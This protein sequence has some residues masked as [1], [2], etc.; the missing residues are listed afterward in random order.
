LHEFA[1]VFCAYHDELDEHLVRERWIEWERDRSWDSTKIAAYGDVIEGRGTLGTT[2]RVDSSAD[3]QLSLL[4]ALRGMDEAFRFVNPTLQGID[5]TPRALLRLQKFVEVHGRLSS[6]EVEGA[7]IPR[8]ARR[9]DPT[10]EVE[11]VRD[12]FTYVQRV[13]PES[14]NRATRQALP[15]ADRFLGVDLRSGLDVACVPVIADPAEM[16]I[17]S[18]TA[19]VHRYYRIA[20]RDLAATLDRIPQIVTALDASGARL[21]VAPEATLSPALLARWQQALRA[22]PKTALRY[23]VAGTG[24]F[25]KGAARAGN[26][27]LLLDGR[28]GKVIGTQ[29]KMYRFDLD[30]DTLGRWE[31]TPWLGRDPIAEDLAVTD[32]RLT[33]FDLGAIRLAI[34]IC[35]DLNKA[36]DVG[37]LVR[38]LGISHLLVPVFSRPVQPY[39][40]EQSAGAVHVRETGTAV[41]VSNSIVMASILRIADPGTSLLVKP[42]GDGAVLG[43]SRDP[44]TAIRFHIHPDGSAE[45]R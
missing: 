3:R 45:I 28:T 5:P 19:G 41:V 24:N 29:D 43:R 15:P 6:D 1:D 23:V 12:L 27:A 22:L 36:L 18:R 30:A 33:V 42:N 16:L 31:L 37:P 32:R 8:V 11:H 38:D 7:L 17:E 25:R 9:D 2:M 44:A 4:A 39:H 35:E 10:A 40:W 14:W 34:L 13:P 20:P 21:A 26:T